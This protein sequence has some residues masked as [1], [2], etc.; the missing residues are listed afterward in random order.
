MFDV[1][2]HNSIDSTND[3]A[4]RLAVA[5]APHG[6]VVH[7]DQ[8]AS[9]RGRLA[10]KWFSPPGNLYISILLRYDLKPGQAG[11][12]S[13]L[14]ALAVADT[15]D[16]LLPKQQRAL[17]KWPND[18]LVGGAKISGILVE[19]EDGAV[20]IGIGLNVVEAPSNTSYSTTTLAASG[21][22]ATV[23]GARTILLQRMQEHL[24][25]WEQEGFL[26]I[27]AAWLART[28][29]LGE[30]LSVATGGDRV[31]GVFVGLDSDGALLLDTEHGRERVVAGDVSL[32]STSDG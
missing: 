30:P 27:R 29:P 23:D 3:E 17:L 26:P 7:A 12:L 18:V 20:I 6:T 22:I 4:R 25:R 32:G 24:T 11:E 10:R 31:E 5:G 2:H 16:A 28:H 14:S 1:Q 19:Q 9:G 15:V 21:G 8:Q 13:F